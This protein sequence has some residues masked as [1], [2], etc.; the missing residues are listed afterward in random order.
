MPFFIFIAIGFFFPW[1]KQTNKQKRKHTNKP[2][3]KR[4]NKNQDNRSS[5]LLKGPSPPDHVPGL[6]RELRH[7]VPRQQ[8]LAGPARLLHKWQQHDRK[9]D[10]YL[11]LPGISKET[12]L[13]TEASTYL[14]FWRASLGPNVHYCLVLFRLGVRRVARGG[15]PMS[16]VAQILFFC[17]KVYL[18]TLPNA[19]FERCW[20]RRTWVT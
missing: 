17:V 16:P 19:A 8:H 18:V 13:F 14:W 10:L 20:P 3:E 2:Q 1:E 4:E 12:A 5:R 6:L 15:E 7:V 9:S 11:Q